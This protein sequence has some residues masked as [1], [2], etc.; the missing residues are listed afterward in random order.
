MVTQKSSVEPAYSTWKTGLPA[1]TNG[2]SL[3][4]WSQPDALLVD[5]EVEVRGQCGK[6]R[7]VVDQPGGEAQRAGRFGQPAVEQQLVVEVER[8]AGARRVPVGVEERHRAESLAPAEPEPVSQS[9]WSA[10]QLRTS[11]HRLSGRRPAAPR[12]TSGNRLASGSSER[13]D[14]TLDL[15]DQPA[16]PGAQL[17]GLRGGGG[18]RVEQ[19]DVGVHHRVERAARCHCHCQCRA[20]DAGHAVG[21]PGGVRPG[22]H[23]YAALSSARATPAAGPVPVG[24]RRRVRG[25]IRIGS[26]RVPGGRSPPHRYAAARSVPASLTRSNERGGGNDARSARRREDLRPVRPV[27]VGDADADL[28]ERAVQ[29]VGPVAG[30]VHP[31]VHHRAAGV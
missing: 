5:S 8:K 4:H 30:A 27:A 28:G 17:S 1:S 13:T 2:S 31:G 10:S 12:T 26:S 29:D 14:P 25:R 6:L 20:G 16:V 23:A 24:V 9:R 7:H 19:E 15:A 21:A 18:H 11:S 22:R 3:A